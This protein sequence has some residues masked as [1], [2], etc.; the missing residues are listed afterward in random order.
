MSKETHDCQSRKRNIPW[1]M[2]AL[3]ETDCGSCLGGCDLRYNTEYKMQLYLPTTRPFT[4]T[5]DRP[6][7]TKT[8]P[9]EKGRQ[10][11]QT[12]EALS[13]IIY[14]FLCELCFPLQPISL[15]FVIVICE[16]FTSN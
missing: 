3:M 1:P 13:F 11:V 12:E 8:V 15:G 10:S 14:F 7:V 6:G 16:F 5:Y 4:R 9:A 2:L